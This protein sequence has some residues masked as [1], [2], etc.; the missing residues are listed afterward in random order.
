MLDY[1]AKTANKW[2]NLLKDNGCEIDCIQ[3]ENTISETTKL[4]RA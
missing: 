3:G 2:K 1:K 4:K